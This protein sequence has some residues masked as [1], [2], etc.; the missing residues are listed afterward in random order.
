M[1]SQIA[2]LDGGSIRVRC[3]DCYKLYAV[4]LRD[5]QELRPRFE[6]VVC[7]SQF[8]LSV[9]EHTQVSV[10]PELSAGESKTKTEAKSLKCPKCEKPHSASD[11]ECPYCGIYFA[12]YHSRAQAIQ[13]KNDE[14]KIGEKPLAEAWKKVIE[15][16]DSEDTHREFV[17]K[18]QSMNQLTLAAEQYRNLLRAIPGDEMALKMQQAIVAL[19]E[20]AS[21]EPTQ[22]RRF[23]GRWLT[24]SSIFY[25]VGS[26]VMVTGYLLPPFRN[27]MGFGAAILFLTFALKISFRR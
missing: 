6:C 1:E 7:R 13:K 2:P 26:A 23:G 5:I 4:E 10:N 24:I 8:S 20:I 11:H 27:M 22:P 14:L 25:T 17:A 12:K 19:T 21:A 15:D 18:C 9:P 3:P 16:F